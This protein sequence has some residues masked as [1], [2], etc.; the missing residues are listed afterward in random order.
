[1][2][3]LDHFD[4]ADEGHTWKQR[5]WVNKRHYM[6]GMRGVPV[7]VLDG[8]ETS[9]EVCSHSCISAVRLFSPF[10]SIC[11][12]CPVSS[13]AQLRIMKLTRFGYNRTDCNSLIPVS[14]ISSAKPLVVSE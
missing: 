7:V 14:S 6:P 5:Y 12:C 4:K 2:Q 3:P 13:M 9:G 11:K 1:V 10:C 8:G